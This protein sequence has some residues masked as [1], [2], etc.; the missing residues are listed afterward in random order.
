MPPLVPV[1][2]GAAAAWPADPYLGELSRSF[3]VTIRRGDEVIRQND[4]QGLLRYGIGGELDVRRWLHLRVTLGSSRA[5]F[6]RQTNIEPEA[7]LDASI[8]V[9]FQL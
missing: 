7:K 6:D 9:I 8:G 4:E 3:E 1:R 2:V 5:K